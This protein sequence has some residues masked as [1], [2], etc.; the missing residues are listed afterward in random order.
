MFKNRVDSKKEIG[1]K[2]VVPM[3]ADSASRWT[4]HPKI[5]VAH[6]SPSITLA[7]LM[8]DTNHHPPAGSILR[9]C[10]CVWK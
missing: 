1:M 9:V 6:V 7:K 3:P 10:V 4:E 8:F 5:H 2:G